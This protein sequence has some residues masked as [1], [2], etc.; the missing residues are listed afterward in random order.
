M[1]ITIPTGSV[2]RPASIIP[3]GYVAGLESIMQTGYVAGMVGIIQTGDVAIL[4]LILSLLP[5]AKYDGKIM[6]KAGFTLMEILVG[7]G[8]LAILTS[9]AT[10]S[11]RGYIQNVEKRA[12]KDSGVLFATALNIC[13]KSMGEDPT[14]CNNVAKLNFTCPKNAYCPIIL[15]TDKTGFCLNIEQTKPS[16]KKLQV[17]TIF[18]RSNMSNYVQYCGEPKKNFASVPP[19]TCTMSMEYHFAQID[20]FPFYESDGQTPK[21]DDNG[22]PLYHVKL[23]KNCT[24]W[25]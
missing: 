4:T 18:E 9:I 7:V 1:F 24:N 20:N 16:G 6:S 15:S 13:I 8:I 2:A 5:I 21:T 12:L 11:Y 14:P 17:V 23:I 10:G 19:A 22:D 25:Q 3:T